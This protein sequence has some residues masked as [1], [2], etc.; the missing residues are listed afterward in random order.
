MRDIINKYAHHP[1]LQQLRDIRSLGLIA[2]AVIVLLVSWSGVKTI[3]LNYRLEQQV[4]EL[5]QSND[6]QKLENDNQR[7]R[8]DYYKTPQY[9]ELAARKNF[10]LALPG[11]KELLV[12]K[13]V[14][15]SYVAGVEPVD[16][17]TAAEP[18]EA[19]RKLPFYQQNLQAWMNF[20]L[21]REAV[22]T[23]SN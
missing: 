5:R 20:F 4:A 21:H 11:E 19:K 23:A 10:G 16:K 7:L 1:W 6:I 9:L 8:N 22:D 18:S 14:A 17:A 2:F 13:E 3:Q 12:P 15:L